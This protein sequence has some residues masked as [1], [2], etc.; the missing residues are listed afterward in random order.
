M[1]IK[2]SIWQQQ[3]QKWSKTVWK[4]GEMCHKRKTS[5][6]QRAQSVTKGNPIG[7]HGKTESDNLKKKFKWLPSIKTQIH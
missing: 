4:I 2:N 7:K 3:Q 1:T 6:I 5:V